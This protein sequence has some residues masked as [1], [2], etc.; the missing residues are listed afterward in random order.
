[1][2]FMGGTSVDALDYITVGALITALDDGRLTAV[3]RVAGN[4]GISEAE[5]RKVIYAS[6]IRDS[7]DI[8]LVTD[9]YFAANHVAAPTAGVPI[10]ELRPAAAAFDNTASINRAVGYLKSK[11]GSLHSRLITW[12]R[13]LIPGHCCPTLLA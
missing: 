2:G 13:W 5:R 11:M 7:A 10:T 6:V 9:A 3:L 12:L 1:M 4:D 8:G